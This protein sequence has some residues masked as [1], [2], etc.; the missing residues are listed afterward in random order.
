MD[1]CKH[2]KLLVERKFNYRS[3]QPTEICEQRVITVPSS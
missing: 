1:T 3:G 2:V